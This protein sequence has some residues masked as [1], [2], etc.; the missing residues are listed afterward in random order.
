MIIVVIQIDSYR[1]RR[2]VGRAENRVPS[3]FIGADWT[4]P[5]PGLNLLLCAELDSRSKSAAA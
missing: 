5:L 4:E 2:I 3:L 1:H